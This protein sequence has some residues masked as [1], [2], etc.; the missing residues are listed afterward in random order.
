MV[1]ASCMDELNFQ[2]EVA[3]K[4][5]APNILAIQKA[6]FL[7]QAKIYKNYELPPLTQNLDSIEKEFEEKTFLKAMIKG[8]IIGAVRFILTKGCV[9]IDRI[10]VKPEYQNKGI[11]T[12]LLKKIEA[13][14]PNAIAFQLF[15][16]NKS[17]R[18]IHLYEKI[19]YKVIG[20]DISDQ[21]IELLHLEKKP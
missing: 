17:V 11:G 20:Q 12:A 16:G 18:N 1:M 9:I 6:A 8:E 3:S 4:N 2:I 15:T 21:G 10:V 13:I 7:G 14:I 5:D 19:G